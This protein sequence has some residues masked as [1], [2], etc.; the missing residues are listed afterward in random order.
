MLDLGVT[1]L[2]IVWTIAGIAAISLVYAVWLR[3]KVLAEDEG[4]PRMQEIALAVQEGASAYLNRQFRTLAIFAAIAFGLLFML[5][6]D[7]SI[8]IGRSVFFLLG[9]GFSAAIGYLGMWL[10]VRANVRVAAA[11]MRANGRVLGARIAFRTGGVVGMSV[12]GLGLAGA[13]AV[14]LI[15]RDQAPSVLEGFGFGAALLAM[16]MR[17]GGGIFTKAADVG[18]DLVGK[19]EQS[20]PEDDPRNAATIA[21]NVGDNVGDCAGMAADLFESYA[22]TLVAALILGKAAFGELGLVFPLIVPAIGALTA[23]MGIA[24]TRIRGDESGLTAI[25]RGFYTSA[26]A[27]AVLAGVAAFLYLP[28]SFA[29]LPGVPEVVRSLPGDPRVMAAASVAIGVV[30]AGIILWLTGYFTGTTSAPTMHVARTS[31]TGPAT[32]VLSGIGVG[33]ESAVYTAGIIA[34]AICAV[35]LISGGSMILSLFMIALAGCGLLTTVG[36]I[37]AMDTFGPV[38]DNAQGIAVMSKDVDADGEA[39]LTALDADGNTTKAITKGIA[40]ATAVLAA[41]ALFGSYTDAVNHALSTLGRD[42]GD[43]LVNSMLTYEIVSPITLVGVI[44]GAA[45]V[46]LFSGLLIDAVTR[47]AGAIVFEVRRQFAE[48]PGIM[49]GEARPEYGRVVDICTRDS[50]RELA[51]P[52]LLA[53]SA[54]IAVGFGLGVGPL[55]GFLGGAIVAG[56]LMAVFLANSGGAWDNAKKLVEDGRYGGKHSPAHEAVVIGDTVGD[57]FKDTAGPAINPLIKVM[58]LVALLIAPAVVAITVGAGANPALRITIGVGAMLVAMG[59]VVW[60]R[61]R[62]HRVDVEA[63]LEHEMHL[64]EDSE[65]QFH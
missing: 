23:V 64:I 9:A 51:T 27:G 15:Y 33:F 8:R 28:A 13:A 49:T 31:L 65:Q 55:A 47:A 22:V 41:T 11:S 2:A 3:R 4:T 54:P 7:L 26:A 42:A 59:G 45:T 29:A 10:A 34:A 6:G 30:L 43:A 20:I 5:P 50:L 57:P 1:S 14:V 16:F 24:I 62:A 44:L 63:R 53:L 60:S 46:F 17:V 21:D 58:N 25:N 39:I 12:V 32:V 48:I 19:V 52:G 37:V 56:V 40:I 61:V 36:V 35:F 18:A 38:S